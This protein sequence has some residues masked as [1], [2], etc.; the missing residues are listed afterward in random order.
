[1]LADGTDVSWLWDVDF[2]ALHGKVAQATVSGIRAADMALRLKY[3]GALP[4]QGEITVQP[5]IGQALTDALTATPSGETLYVLPTYT[6][7]LEVKNALA[8]RGLSA[9]WQDD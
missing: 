4:A 2:E 9:R 3:A 5:G 8:Q 6:A 1:M 7:M